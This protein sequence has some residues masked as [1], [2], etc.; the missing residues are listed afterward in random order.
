M[1][2]LLLAL[3]SGSV[4]GQET[5]LLNEDFAEITEGNSTS[6]G[7]SNFD[8]KGNSNFPEVVAAIKQVEV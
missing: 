8:W 2:L 3:V 7:G 1:T 6:T 4:W 5:V